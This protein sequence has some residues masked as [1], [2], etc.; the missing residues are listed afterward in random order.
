MHRFWKVIIFVLFFFT[1]AVFVSCAFAQAAT[2]S[3]Q[4][5]IKVTVAGATLNV[6][7]Y[8]AP[9]ASVVMTIDNNIIGS[10][11]ADAQGNFSFANVTVPQTTSTVCFTAEDFKQLGT[12]E[13]CISVKQIDGVISVANVF[14]PPTLG[15]QRTDVQVGNDAVVFGY[16]MPGAQITVHL[17]TGIGCITT[18]DSTGYYQCHI[19]I[20][21]IGSNTL[22]ADATLNGKPS[23]QQLKKV[24]IQGL[25]Y[26]KPTP[27]PTLGFLLSP[28]P[29][30]PGLPSLSALPWW[31]WVLLALIAIILI[32]ILLR[33]F[34]P[35]AVPA[36]GMPSVP[37]GKLFHTFDKFFRSRKLHHAWMKGVGY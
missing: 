19:I 3:G 2:Q 1:A 21:T 6:S 11:V 33:K 26:V 17:N 9:Y 36:V 20:R 28:T 32:I 5:T 27:G 24:L 16:G 13:A 31:I 22:Y 15:V 23:E 25:T 30:I 37:K 7:G 4:T 34:R 35:E 14:I 12:S 8:I 18:A 10:V 29:A